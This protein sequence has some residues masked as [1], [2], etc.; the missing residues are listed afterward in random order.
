MGTEHEEA[1]CELGELRFQTVI[2]REAAA[3]ELQELDEER[4]ELLLL[5]EAKNEEVS[6]ASEHIELLQCKISSDR[7][8][9]SAYGKSERRTQ[10]SSCSSIDLLRQMSH[11]RLLAASSEDDERDVEPPSDGTEVEDGVSGAERQSHLAG[12]ARPHASALQGSCDMFRQPQV[13]TSNSSPAGGTVNVPVSAY[14]CTKPNGSLASASQSSMWEMFKTSL[15]CCGRHM[16][17]PRAL[18]QEEGSR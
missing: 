15:S 2:D 8:L 5:L 13:A 11:A 7:S 12:A 10:T 9:R 18:I 16:N 1:R 3:R 6:A 17:E 4:K 14:T